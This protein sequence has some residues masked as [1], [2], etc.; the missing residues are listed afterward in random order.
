MSKSISIP[1]LPEMKSALQDALSKLDLGVDVVE[2]GTVISVGDGVAQVQGLSNAFFHEMVEFECGGYGLIMNLQRHVVGVVLFCE[3]SKVNEGETVKRT[4]KLLEVPV[5]KSLLGRV[6]NSL[7]EP[8]D[9]RGAIRSEHRSPIE[10]GAPGIVDRESVSEPMHTG[11]KAVDT[12]IPI[13]KGQRELII[14][15]RQTGKTSIVVDAILNQK[16]L[17]D[18]GDDKNSV[19]CVYVALGQKNS[20]VARTVKMLEEKGALSYTV[21][22]VASP[23][24]PVPFQFLAPYAG[25]AMGE[26]FRDRG[27]HAL[28]VYDDLSKHAVAYR[29][30]SLLLR[31]P[32]G[33]EAY[34]GDVFYIHSRLL[35][36]AA[37][38]SK[39]KGGGSLTALPIIET[40]AGDVSAYIPTNVI[41]ITDGQIFLETDLFNQ[42]QKPAVNLGLSVS[43]VGSAA[44]QK[45][46]KAVAGSTKLDLAQ[47]RELEAFSQF[48][49]DVDE[50]TKKI[51]AKGA[52]L[53]H[54]LRQR[55]THL[56]TPEEQVALFFAA[57]EGYLEGIKLEEIGH[58]EREFLIYLGSK[59]SELMEKIGKTGDLTEEDKKS[60]RGTLDSF[61]EKFHVSTEKS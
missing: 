52:K 50:S 59:E 38:M 27:Q 58:F 9:G 22:V 40:Q 34:P 37:K 42:G 45:S 47:Y 55:N 32:P 56:L 46:M 11:I 4:K 7:G 51:L 2:V 1:K 53:S 35:E 21:V 19:F 6:V 25:C 43:R 30:I 31:R 36:R 39:E 5:G 33:R 57:N 44:Q 48:S 13:G 28:V 15:D 16:R 49:S 26:Y 14:G 41:S 60:L 12:L 54:M 61:L 24:D 3:D 8:L 29:Q 20:S 18:K 23:S 10:L 17:H